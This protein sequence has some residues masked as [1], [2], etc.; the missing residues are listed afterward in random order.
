MGLCRALAY[1]GLALLLLHKQGSIMVVHNS[2]SFDYGLRFGR[3]CNKRVVLVDTRR[4]RQGATSIWGTHGHDRCVGA[5]GEGK[6]RKHQHHA[7]TS[8]AVG[9]F[10]R[11]QLHATTEQRHGL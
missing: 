7:F 5:A 11:C 6:A 10:C 2:S 1:P 3:L 9:G 8:A 4:G